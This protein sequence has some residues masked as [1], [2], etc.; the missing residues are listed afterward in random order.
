[1]T[2]VIDDLQSRIAYQEDTINTLNQQVITLDKEVH[3]LQKQ[4][5]LLYKK[6]DDVVY[7]L[8]QGQTT[9]AALHDER[10]PHY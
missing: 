4:L 3:D 2:E 9:V 7:Q 1:M 5:H 8:E 6:V 10:P